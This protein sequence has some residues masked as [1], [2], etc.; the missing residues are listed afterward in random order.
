MGTGGEN[1]AGGIKPFSGL[2]SHAG[3]S[4]GTPRCFML[5]KLESWTHFLKVTATF[6]TQNLIPCGTKFLREFI[7]AD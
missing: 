4:S 7:F 5:Q 1:S 3:G 6:Q 2:A